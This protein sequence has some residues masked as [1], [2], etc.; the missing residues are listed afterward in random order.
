MNQSEPT[1]QPALAD[2]L[3]A[4]RW[5]LRSRI[6]R[7]VQRQA[8]SARPNAHEDT[9]RDLDVLLSLLLAAV[10][11][12]R[13]SGS[14]GDAAELAQ[15]GATCATRGYPLADLLVIYRILLRVIVEYV[16]EMGYRIGAHSSEVLDTVDLVL[17]ICNTMTADVA[18]GYH[19]VD[20]QRD[21][22]G[23]Q[24][25]E[26]VRGLLWGT[27]D[28]AER[29]RH[30]IAYRL[31]TARE[32]VA[33]RARPRPGSSVAELA[34]AHGFAFGRAPGGGLS[35]VVHGDLVGFLRVPPG[36]PVPGVSGIGPPRPLERLHESF[37]MASRALETATRRNLAGVREFG[38]LGLLPA[39]F[40]DG[41]I[42]AALCR[43]Y[44]APLGETEFAV[45][46]VDTLRMYLI[47]G[48]H[49]GRTAE[50]IFVHPNTVRYRISRFEEL[51]GV[52]LRSNPAAA[53]EVLWALEHWAA[54]R[55]DA[56][57]SSTEP[58]DLGFTRPAGSPG[59]RDVRSRM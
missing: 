42:G 10:R 13:V 34:R 49:V 53:F 7:A 16:R 51:T 35:A 3:A 57:V 27:L 22:A 59:R 36:G 55:D 39:M 50:Q 11:E 45:E 19:S 8:P 1:P 26:F 14:A 29:D 21:A 9:V 52:S 48:M 32:Y 31:D 43:R 24:R 41:A 44:L 58:G 38:Q 18:V 15:I 2:A 4:S 40:S 30:L 47:H 46:I 23:R 54:R 6:V 37:R 28:A 17:R 25:A 20:P 12:G 5:P 56:L 33:L